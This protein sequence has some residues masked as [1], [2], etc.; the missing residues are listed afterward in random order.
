MD[1]M[2]LE[3]RKFGDGFTIVQVEIFRRAGMKT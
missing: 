3:G 1:G 2:L